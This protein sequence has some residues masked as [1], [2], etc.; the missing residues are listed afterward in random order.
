[1]SANN[2]MGDSPLSKLP[3]YG[4]ISKCSIAH[5]SEDDLLTA[6]RLVDKKLR[7]LLFTCSFETF[8]AT[9]IRTLKAYIKKLNPKVSVEEI[10]SV[11]NCWTA[12]ESEKLIC[13]YFSEYA[14]GSL[15]SSHNETV[16]T[17]I[18]PNTNSSP[19]RH[20]STPNKLHLSPP[21]N[22]DPLD[23]KKGVGSTVGSKSSSLS[24]SST[25][26]NAANSG[27]RTDS[28][29][30]IPLYIP[31]PYPTP[32]PF[33]GVGGNQKEYKVFVELPDGQI[34]FSLL[35]VPDDSI[36][37]QQKFNRFAFE[38]EVRQEFFKN[39]FELSG[40]TPSKL[41]T[42]TVGF[43]H[44]IMQRRQVST[45]TFECFLLSTLENRFYSKL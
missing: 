16:F 42:L 21:T 25:S 15:V 24:E 31:P 11:K 2:A 18:N 9:P 26:S 38:N 44:D 13:S 40:M 41:F 3:N 1:M 23:L 5:E 43:T 28:K 22:F 10:R 37:F 12:R 17:A 34:G 45:C 8:D 4:S 6:E 27:P 19:S 7:L 36:F 35:D 14:D 29:R 30:T 32:L 39:E 33:K 20:F